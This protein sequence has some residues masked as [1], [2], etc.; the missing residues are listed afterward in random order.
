MWYCTVYEYYGVWRTATIIAVVAT[1]VTECSTVHNEDSY[2][3][4]ILSVHVPENL[5]NRSYKAFLRGNSKTSC[6]LFVY[7][8]DN[9]KSR[10]CFSNN[11]LMK[12]AP[13]LHDY[14]V[15]SNGKTKHLCTGQM[16]MTNGFA[17]MLIIRLHDV[18]IAFSMRK[19]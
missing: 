5:S 16:V 14:R 9:Q 12:L 15:L 2:P 6:M 18:S 8:C 1:G 3:K 10:R 11:I 7:I 19:V 13:P 17:S 4:C